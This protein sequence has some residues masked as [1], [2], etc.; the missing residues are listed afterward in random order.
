MK[1]ISFILVLA[2]MLITLI[3]PQFISAGTT[4]EPEPAYPETCV[5]H[6]RAAEANACRGGAAAGSTVDIPD[7]PLCCIL[8]GIYRITDWIFFFLLAL[9]VL[10]VLLGAFSLLTAA[11][12]PGKIEK[13]RG[14][15]LWAVVGFIIALIAWFI[16]EIAKLIIGFQD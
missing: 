14:Y 7:D 10:F 2:V 13:G 4:D 11:G 16:P 9:V 6:R 5:V 1:K 12:D 8:S 15:I 3:V